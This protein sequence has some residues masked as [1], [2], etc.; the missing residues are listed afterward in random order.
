[1]T[2]LNE[3]IIDAHHHLWRAA[4]VPWLSGPMQPRIFGEY[5]AIRRDYMP[6]EYLADA[7]P[8]GVVKSVYIQVNVAPG[9]EVEEVAWVQSV[10]NAHGFPHGIVAYAD[11]CDPNVAETLDREQ[12]HSRLRGIRQQLHWHTDPRYRFAQRPDVM[13]DSAFRHGMGLLAARGLLFELQVFASQMRDAARLV[14]AF[15][16]VTFVLLHAGMPEDRRPEGWMRWR[17]GMRA[18]A[19]NANVYVKLSGLGTFTRACSVDLWK[20]VIEETLACFGPARCVFGSNFPVEKLWTTYGE[21][22]AV[23][24]ACLTGLSPQERRAVLHDNA[25]RL[26]RL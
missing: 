15:P 9:E 5:A 12:V 19:A 4:R 25:A 20:P 23:T 1:V 21:I 14:A 26:Y 7:A 10:G 13:N 8:H 24:K 17:E 18:L 2:V 22:V 16:Q 6:E 11:L 3:P